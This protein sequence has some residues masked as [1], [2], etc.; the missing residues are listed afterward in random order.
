VLATAINTCS[1]NL[2]KDPTVVILPSGVKLHYHTLNRQNDRS[3]ATYNMLIL[4]PSPMRSDTSRL[5]APT[6]RRR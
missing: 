4:A 2:E 1:F 6:L 3:A 5:Q